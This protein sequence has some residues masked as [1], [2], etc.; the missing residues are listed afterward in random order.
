[1][2]ITITRKHGYYAAGAVFIVGLGFT[3]G[4]IAGDGWSES[5]AAWAQAVGT[6]LAILAST[7]VAHEIRTSDRRDRLDDARL[8]A[9]TNGR[10]VIL[11]MSIV[12]EMAKKYGPLTTTIQGHLEAELVH[13]RARLSESN[14]AALGLAALQRSLAGLDA[15]AGLCQVMTAM[16]EPDIGTLTGF[17]ADAVKHYNGAAKLLNVETVTVETVMSS[18]APE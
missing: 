1:M 4:F 5:A 17:L 16:N 15:S 8:A 11:W 12:L 2:Q 6:I 7:I 3:A 10:L 14:T 9:L 18:F 13:H